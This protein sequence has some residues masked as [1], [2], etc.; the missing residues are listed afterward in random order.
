MRISD[1]SSDVCSSDLLEASCQRHE[2]AA[3]DDPDPIGMDLVEESAFDG[4]MGMGHTLGADHDMICGHEVFGLTGLDERMTFLSEAQIFLLVEPLRLDAGNKARIGAD[5]DI[6]M[7]GLER[8]NHFIA[9]HRE[10]AVAG[11]WCLEPR[12]RMHRRQNDKMGDEIGRASGRER[13]C[14]EE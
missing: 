1:W 4:T 2:K 11:V 7:P 14:R 8:A 3:R 10:C 12:R 13:E 9:A 6:D 5:G